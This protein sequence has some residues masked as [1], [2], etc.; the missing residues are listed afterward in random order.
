MNQKWI[1]VFVRNQVE[2]YSVKGTNVALFDCV[3]GEVL[4]KNEEMA[5]TPM[6]G[7]SQ[8]TFESY[9]PVTNAELK[10][11]IVKNSFVYLKV[12]EEETS[13]VPLRVA[14]KVII[15]FEL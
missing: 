14:G 12:K 5:F 3:K 2:G 11:L 7:S 13:L 15:K 9:R 4:A 8:F 6:E 10:N 1:R